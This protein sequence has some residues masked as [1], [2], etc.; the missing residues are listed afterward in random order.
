MDR[1]AQ[2]IFQ[3]LKVIFKNPEKRDLYIKKG[4]EYY[5]RNNFFEKGQ[6]RQEFTEEERNKLSLAQLQIAKESFES[7]GLD[8][9]SIRSFGEFLDKYKIDRDLMKEYLNQRKKV[10]E[11]AL[12]E[13]DNKKD[14][15]GKK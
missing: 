13:I 3:M 14:N 10:I 4:I 15:E 5:F 9:K 7:V 12:S 11:R 2:Q 1:R 6:T 8:N